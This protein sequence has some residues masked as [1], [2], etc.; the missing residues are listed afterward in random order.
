[1]PDALLALM[2]VII[3]VIIVVTMVSGIRIILP[4]EQG[5]LIVLGSFRRVLNPGMNWV[6]PFISRVVK[7]DLRTQVVEIPRQEGI[8]KDEIQVVMDAI[9]YLRV[10]DPK[11]AFFEITNYRV[12]TMALAQTTLR[13]VLM[14]TD[15]DGIVKDRKDFCDRVKEKLSDDVVRW[16]VKVEA[17][18]VR[19]LDVAFD[20][21]EGSRGIVKHLERL[22]KDLDDMEERAKRLKKALEE[23]MAKG[24]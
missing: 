12:A 8:T 20:M 7:I 11:K 6:Q 5:L 21:K 19:D 9:L 1:M 14:D 2:I 3:V 10:V 24:R 23:E 18:E 17:F 16:G 13:F 15:V 22:V 4:Y